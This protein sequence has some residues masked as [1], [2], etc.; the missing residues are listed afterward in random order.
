MCLCAQ[1]LLI[2]CDPMDSRDYRLPPD[3][4]MGI[5]KI[6]E[7]LTCTLMEL[8]V[9]DIKSANERSLYEVACLQFSTPVGDFC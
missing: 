2:L 6:V 7:Y 5:H 1:S 3:S 8:P 9:Q 4:G